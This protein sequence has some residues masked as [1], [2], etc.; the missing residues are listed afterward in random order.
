MARR[1]GSLPRP[2]FAIGRWTSTN[3]GSAQAQRAFALDNWPWPHRHT[4]LKDK[5]RPQL[6]SCLPGLLNSGRVGRSNGR[7]RNARNTLTPR[8]LV[9][10]PLAQ[11]WLTLL[12]ASWGQNRAHFAVLFL[13]T[14]LFCS[15][16]Q[17][18]RFWDLFPTPQANPAPALVR[19]RPDPGW[20]GT[21]A[22][23][24]S[25]RQ[26]DPSF[27]ACVWPGS[28]AQPHPT[29]TPRPKAQ[30][31]ARLQRLAGSLQW[32]G[33]RCC[34]WRRP[35]RARDCSARQDFRDGAWPCPSPHFHHTP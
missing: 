21:R 10:G 12:Q 1:S 14:A 6:A 26:A 15:V 25:N 22:A 20:S 5:R 18:G 32:L 35:R 2:E 34:D 23:L 31:I 33:A 7:R 28:A 4:T 24:A 19:L 17:G 29:Q 30:L 16:L 9:V 27:V 3:A 8:P 11:I 13:A